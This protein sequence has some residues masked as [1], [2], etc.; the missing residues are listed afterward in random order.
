M[1]R[2]GWGGV[3]IWVKVVGAGVGVVGWGMGFVEGEWGPGGGNG[4]G[5]IVEGNE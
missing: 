3:A 4:D 5:G 2:G 1:G